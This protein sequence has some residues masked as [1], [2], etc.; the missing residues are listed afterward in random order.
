MTTP[1]EIEEQL[2]GLIAQLTG[3]T[4]V[5]VNLDASWRT[6]GLDSLDLLT[7]VLES[8]RAFAVSIPDEQALRLRSGRDVVACVRAALTDPAREAGAITK[9]TNEC[10]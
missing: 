6:L 7:L 2:A 9:P 10:R 1:T 4:P 5:A 8:E 3:L